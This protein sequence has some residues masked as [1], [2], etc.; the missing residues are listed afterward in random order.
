MKFVGIEYPDSLDGERLSNQI[1]RIIS[2]MTDG[3]WRTHLEIASLTMSPQSSVSSQLRNLRMKE[4]GGY[5]VQRRRRGE[6]KSGLFEY[7]VLSPRMD[8]I[9]YRGFSLGHGHPRFCGASV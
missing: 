3:E 9:Y 5:E 2:L 7:R 6:K 8:R 1:E 4:N